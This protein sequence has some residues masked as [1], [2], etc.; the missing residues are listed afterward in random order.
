MRK[1]TKHYPE[2]QR[3]L[4]R[5]GDRVFISLEAGMSDVAHDMYEYND[6]WMT[7]LETENSQP[8]DALG[9]SYVL[10]EDDHY[11][12]WHDYMFI[13]ERETRRHKSKTK[14]APGMP[15]L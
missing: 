8:K 5:P 13:T 12:F 3:G 9:H 1:N 10:E 6:Q 7:I 4:L 15:Q 2:R 11:W 14:P